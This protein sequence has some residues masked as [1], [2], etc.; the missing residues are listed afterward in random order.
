MPKKNEAPASF[1]TAL[2]ELEQ[3]VNRLESGSLPLEEALNEFERGV[4]L[5][6]QG[7]TKL[8]QAEQRVQILL[9]DNEDSPLE[10]FTP[11]AE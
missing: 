8:Q 2:T 1:E 6:R 5:A 3:I 4:Q 9:A 7:Q 11:D 10:P